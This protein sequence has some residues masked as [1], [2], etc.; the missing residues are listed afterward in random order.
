VGNNPILANVAE[1]VKRH[2]LILAE[3]VL[4]TLESRAEA[5]LPSFIRWI[6]GPIVRRQRDGTKH[7]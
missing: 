2:P 7:G 1:F 5:Q 4:D 6:R 3:S